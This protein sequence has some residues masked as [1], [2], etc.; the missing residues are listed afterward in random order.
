M[1]ARVTWNNGDLTV[2]PPSNDLFDSWQ[3]KS[4]IIDCGNSGTTCRLLA[5]L[6]AG[7]LPLDSPGVILQG[8]ASLS[9]RPMSRIVDPLQSM[10]ANITWL[11]KEGHLPFLV[12]GATLTARETALAVPSAQIKSALLLAGLNATGE[13]SIL[14]SGSSRDHTERLLRLMGIDV[15]QNTADDCLKI[16]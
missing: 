4:I 10:G 14:G 2:I 16:K 6:L 1:G 8:D 15:I 9:S 13:T 5:G 11:E 7:W 12:Q 3:K